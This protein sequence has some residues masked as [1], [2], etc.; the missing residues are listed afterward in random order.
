LPP[1]APFYEVEVAP[2]GQLRAAH[3]PEQQSRMTLTTR[4]LLEVMYY[5]SHA[6]SVPDEHLKKGLVAVTHNADG[7][8]FDWG[9]VTGD[10]FR[11]QV[12]K[13]KPKRAAVAIHYRGYW[14]WIDDADVASKTT[15]ALF[16]ELTRLRKVGAAE[17]Q[18]LLT[19]P[20]GR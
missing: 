16:R 1:G 18:P 20:V 3:R 10:L 5:L 15:L 11:V 2:G 17:G 14:F 12:C 8:A 9:Q 7:S 13:H 19:L 4:S 6:V